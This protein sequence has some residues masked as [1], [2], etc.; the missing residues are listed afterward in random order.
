VYGRAVSA[1]GKKLHGHG[2]RSK[3]RSPAGSVG[4][5]GY[6]RPPHPVRVVV[7]Q[8]FWP[9]RAS[10]RRPFAVTRG[11]RGEVVLGVRTDGA[12]ERVKTTER[13]LLA[14]RVDGQGLHY[15]FL[16]WE[17]R[18]YRTWGVVV[19]IDAGAAVLV[20]PEWHPGR[21][22]RLPTRLMPEPAGVGSW[23]MLRADL[24][25][26]AAGQLNP[27]GFVCCED[28]GVA[29]CPRPTWGAGD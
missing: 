8:R 10:C 6:G 25:V 22:V 18:R 15:S 23:L 19:A 11:P 1:A 16:G 14:V 20:L 17:P 9:R 27:S 26:P 3:A 29:R 12:R 28:P 21:P 2:A 24:S 5:G 4:D 13:R 7:G